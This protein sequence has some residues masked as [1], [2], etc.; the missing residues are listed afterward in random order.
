M[1]EGVCKNGKLLSVK[2]ERSSA[3]RHKK[4][5]CCKQRARCEYI[6][7]TERWKTLLGCLGASKCSLHLLRLFIC[8][9]S[10]IGVLILFASLFKI[11][12][13][14]FV[15]TR[16]HKTSRILNRS[17]LFSNNYRIIQFIL[18]II[19]R[20]IF[21]GSIQFSRYLVF[22]T[23]IFQSLSIFK[24]IQYCIRKLVWNSV[25]NSVLKSE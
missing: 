8:R 5:A 16:R 6:F 10:F 25:W 7:R 1:R 24:R 21:S 17:R 15:K 13:M 11:T 4:A 19:N 22:K 20:R 12:V 9:T 23:R 2:H 3:F 18:N 14:I